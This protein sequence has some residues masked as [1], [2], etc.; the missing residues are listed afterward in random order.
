MHDPSLQ[1]VRRAAAF[2]S[3]V[4][5]NGLTGVDRIAPV[6]HTMDFALTWDGYDLI[7]TLSRSGSAL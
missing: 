1:A 7:R 2:E 6:G 5:E 3:T 4:L